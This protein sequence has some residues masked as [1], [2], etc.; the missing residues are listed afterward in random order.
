MTTALLIIDVQESLCVGAEAAFDIDRVVDRINSLSARARAVGA[1]V[2][3]I[4]H[5]EEEGPLQFG[6]EGW[7]L[8]ERLAIA[9][10]DLRVRKTA[11]DSFHQTGLEALLQ[12][13]GVGRLIICGLQS[14][15][16]IDATVRGA[17]AL[18]YPVVL[19]SDAHSTMDSGGRTAAEITRHHNDALAG[20][21]SGV[22]PMPAAE[23]PL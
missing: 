3:L 6:S 20:L 22:Q 17:H 4:Q 21:G 13:R 19:V 9:P 12:A 8:Y 5:E 1:P 16:C 14:D 18:G 23:V 7:Q 2:I 15:Y 11:C 10:G